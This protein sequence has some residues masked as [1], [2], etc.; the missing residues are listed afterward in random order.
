MRGARPVLTCGDRQLALG[1]RT[2]V[3]GILNVTPDS[4]SDGGQFAD[5]AAAIGHAR[6]MLKAGADVIDVGGESTRPGAALVD[7]E[8]ELGRVLPV[9]EGLVAAGITCLSVDTRRPA[10]AASALAA[11]ASWVNDVGGLLAPGMLEVATQADAVVVMHQRQAALAPAAEQAAFDGREDSVVYDDVVGEVAA[12]LNDRADAFA[13]A[14]GDRRRLLVDPGIGFGK[15]IE[16]NLALTRRLRE[17]SAEVAGVLYG[18]SRKRFIGALMQGLAGEVDAGRRGPGSVG[19]ALY[20][21]HAGADV[22]RV[23]DVEATVGALRVFD[24]LRQ[25]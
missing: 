17:L 5:A 6:A 23:H 1:A 8:E 14:G 4:F 9:I 11:G 25:A 19:A 22:V 13:A 12:F 21:A 2:W 18:A 16:D 15:R 10:V 7:E 24:A 3:M 20:A